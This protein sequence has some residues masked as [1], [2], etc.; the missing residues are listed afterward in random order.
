MSDGVSGPVEV[1]TG[2]V[3]WG[4]P[5]PFTGE[6]V[7]ASSERAAWHWSEAAWHPAPAARTW[8]SSWRPLPERRGRPRAGPGFKEGR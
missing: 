4:H 2:A 5:V 3:V 7:E 8:P 1:W 6:W